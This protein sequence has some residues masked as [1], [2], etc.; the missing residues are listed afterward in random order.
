MVSRYTF[1]RPHALTIIDTTKGLLIFD[2]VDTTAYSGSLSAIA[3]QPQGRMVNP[4]VISWTSFQYVNASGYVVKFSTGV[5]PVSISLLN[6]YEFSWVPTPI[7]V[8]LASVFNVYS[9]PNLPGFTFISCDIKNATGYLDFTFGSSTTNGPTIQVPYRG[10][11]DQYALAN[12]STVCYFTFVDGGNTGPYYL[13][14]NFLRA[15]YG[16]S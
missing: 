8:S 16:K 5:L 3:L 11:G 15:A 13:S 6:G 14:D 12:G 9:D 2:G 4:W 10:L 1:T 7:Y